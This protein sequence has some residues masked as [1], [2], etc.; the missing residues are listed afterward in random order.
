MFRTWTARIRKHF[1]LAGSGRRGPLS[2]AAKP[3]RL[4][5]ELLEDRWLPTGLTGNQ[6][7]AAYGQ[8]PLSFESNVGQTAAQVDFLSHGPGYGLFLTPTEAVLNLS[9]GTGPVGQA[10]GGN[11]VTMTL[12]GASTNSAPTGLD[13][14]AATSNYFI[15]ND[16]SQ[17]HTNIANYG[18]VQYQNVYSGI[19]LLYYGNQQNLEYDFQVAPGADP[20]VIQLAFS[21]VQSLSL[22][23]QGNLM[24][25]TSGGEVVEQTPVVYQQEGA[26]RQE[27][28]GKYVLEG[29]NQVGF[30]VGAY[31][32][33]QPLTI[34]PV[35]SYATYLGGNGQD[36]GFGIAVDASGDAYVTGETPSN[37][38]PT[39]NPLQP[40]YSGGAIYDAF[41]SR[42]NATGTALVYST[43]LGGGGTDEGKGIALDASGNAYITG[44][45]ESDNF[46]TTTGAFQPT[47][48]GGT[49]AF[50]TKLNAT[51]SALIYSTYLGG[52]T[53]EGYAIALNASGNAYV[54]GWTQ[55][56]FPTT[57]GAFQ[58]KFD[59]SANAFVTELN[60]SG[61]ALVYSTY[62]GGSTYDQ[63][64]GI[65]LDAS[66]DAYVTGY[67]ESSDFPTTSNALQPTFGGGFD[68]A[69]VTELNATGTALVYSTFLGGSGNDEG[70]AIAVDAFGNAYVTGCTESSDFPTVNPIQATF[71]G[72][73]GQGG[74][75][76]YGGDAFVAKVNASGTA[77]IYSTYLG[78]SNDDIGWGIAVDG[79]G[80]A[81]IA[82]ESDSSDFPTT[83]NALQPTL[84]FVIDAV[85]AE[86]NP[87]GTALIYSSF[88]GGS[89]GV[90]IGNAIALD[91]SGNAYVTGYTIASDFSTPYSVQSTS[92]DAGDA[93]VAEIGNIAPQNVTAVNDNFTTT[94][95][96]PT[97]LNVLANDINPQG[98]G[99]Q[100]L[101]ATPIS[102]SGPTLTQ[103]ADG[104]F[105][106]TGADTGTYTFNYTITGAQQEV[107]ADDGAANDDFGASVAISGDTAVVGADRHQVGSNL[108][109]GAAYVF[110]LS[111]TT[112]S[113]QQ[114]LTAANGAA[115]DQF[116][117]SVAINGNN[118]VVGAIQFAVGTSGPG[119]A[120]VYTYSGTSWIQEQELT[121][122]DGAEADRFG[123][124]VALSSD[125]LV[126]GAP[127]HQVG[128]NAREGAAY[129]YVFSGGSWSQ[130]QELTAFDGAAGDQIG[131]EVAINGQ[132][133]VVGDFD[134]TVGDNV[135][136]GAVYVYTFSSPIW[137]L[138]QELTA[139]DGAAHDEFGTSVAIDG[140]TIVVGAFNHK[141][142]GNAGQ[143]AAYV[144]TF[145]G[146]TWNQQQEL[147]ANDGTAND[148]FG[149]SVALDGGT[150]VVGAAGREAAYVYSV[151]GSTWSQ[152][153][154]LT[155]ADGMANAFFGVA[156]ALS[157]DTA[158]V[159]AFGQTVDGNTDQ[160]TAY[161]QT[162]STS[163]ALVTVNVTA[164]SAIAATSGSGQSATVN[165]TF[166]NPLIATVTD[167]DN[168]P[169]AGVTVTFTGPGS[170]AGVT[171]PDG[172]TAIT[173]AEGQASVSVAASTGAGSYIVTASVVGVA[174]AAS[175]TLT[176]NPG[177][178]AAVAFHVQPGNTVAGT[179]I[180]PTVQ[181]Q[182]LDEYGNLEADDSSDQVSLAVASGP[183]SFT[184]AST[185][186]VTVSGGI[187]TFNNLVLDTAGSYILGESA[188]G[189]LS[190][191]S[192]GSFIIDP[193]SADHLAFSVPP[194]STTAGSAIAPA[195][196]VQVFDQYD[197]LA[198]NDNS[199]QVTLSAASGPSAFTSGSTTTVTVSGGIAAFSN[200]ILDTAGSYTLS[201]SGSGGITGPASASFTISPA[202]ADHL[203]FGVP[204]SDTTA[205]A[206]INPAVTVQVFDQY[207]NPA[208]NDNSDQVTL[209]VAS[210]PGTFANGS[211]MTVTV[212]GGVATFSNLMLDT[213]G[214][215][216][217]SES[218]SGGITGPASASFTISP[219]A[220]DHLAFDIQPSDTTAGALINPA[221]TVQVFDQYDNLATNDN[222]DQVTLAVASG[223][224]TFA[225]GSTTTV[226]VNSGVATFSN[227]ILDMAG[228]YTLGESGSGGIT[229]PASTSFTISPAAAD[230]LAF[231][232]QP[233]GTPASAL[234]SPA[235]TVRALDPFGNVVTTDVGDQVTLTVASGPGGFTDG[236]T[237][238]A[239][240]SDGVATFSNL[241]LGT[242][243]SYTLA[244]SDSAGLADA[245]SDGFIVAML[246]VFTNAGAAVFTVGQANS[247]TLTTTDIPTAALSVGSAV[248]PVGVIFVDNG[249]GTATLSGTPA[250]GIGIY[251]FN[252]TARN[253]YTAAVNQVFTLTLIDPPI[254][255]SANNAT[256]PVGKAGSFTVTTTAGLPAATTL[257]RSGTLPSGVTFTANSNGTATLH[258]T[259]AAG[260]GGSY[261]I[262]VT[263]GNAAASQTTQT[264]TLT[265]DQTPTISSAANATFV[266]GQA[267]SFTVTTK[268]FP[269]ATLSESDTLPSGVTFLDNG[270]GTATLSGTPET[271][272]ASLTPYSFTITASNGVAPSVTQTFKLTVD[273][274]PVITSA[275]NATFPVG[276]AGSFT[277]TTTAGL[278]AATTLSESDTLPSGVTFTANSNGTAT[279]KGT[280]AAGTGGSYT[281]TLTASNAAAS[282]TTQTFTLTVDQAPTISSAASTTFVMGQAGNFTVTTKGFPVAALTQSGTL[283]SGVTFLDN[284]NGTAT[285]SGTPGAGT[286]S[287]TP[288]NFT[289]TASNG[290][291][292]S[293]TQTFKL[294]VDQAPVIT[295]AN[296]STFTVGKAGSFTVTTTAGLPAATT[297]S[298]SGTL[299]SGV[300][301]TANS[302]GTATIKGT[303]AAGSGGSYPVTITAGN[304]AASLTTQT[305]TLNV[306]QAPTISSAASAT[307]SVGHAGSFTVTTKGFPAAALTES[308]KLPS[309][310]T[311]LD[312]G[313]GTATLS[314]TPWAGSGGT[315]T[316]TISAGNS[317]ASVAQ[318]FVLMV[319]Q[320]PIITSAASATFSVGQ[321][322]SF[323]ITT[324]GYPVATTI[325]EAGPMPSGVRFVNNGN[326]TA[327]L[328]GK[329]TVKGSFTLTLI[330]SVGG[331]PE[332]IQEFDFTVE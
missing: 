296:S 114:E 12:V 103:N 194:A 124:S 170:G 112:W 129:V 8:I 313:N 214:S 97:N 287:L 138:Q 48:G 235:V 11:V 247:F 2:K 162:F 43:Y 295:S 136:Q 244:A 188:T 261:P 151:A 71:D 7:L 192:S 309:G 115:I 321:L 205:G 245:T 317:V 1:Q 304:A 209:S 298:R 216:T 91:A 331:V 316:F 257:S 263:A 106:F 140:N 260:S 74:L 90:S 45:T 152:Q 135:G 325:T 133:I 56:N 314:G 38:F 40:N 88:L 164:P 327:L 256:F 223:P 13:K 83:V 94:V 320:P 41:V 148:N 279:I 198:T 4:H 122:A 246:P 240:V 120:Y 9:K 156:V 15:G 234:I 51:G 116:G 297:L 172:N 182:L 177:A 273:Q 50:V 64:W 280:P 59:A 187:A 28:A 89:D 218:G 193:G 267:G 25:E 46:P 236:S 255:T 6:I 49:D 139:A 285:L 238:T 293:V 305:F 17:W 29:G 268:G 289:I 181:V 169:V 143:G 253:G 299:P 31:D 213:A 14:L 178:A 176:N 307:F 294:T 110:K 134:H 173:N 284:G 328:S 203:V 332:A 222:S 271:G 101:S 229:G 248:L 290:V 119:A 200:L 282:L 226:T 288:Y 80:D 300:T 118:I 105:T 73:S 65:A 154:E 210:G 132:T 272:T 195:V 301:F 92:G 262:T 63:G 27:V 224:D 219:A 251:T 99:L 60:V 221:V 249:D 24:L 78:G 276:K 189:G 128:S 212:S 137:N 242:A 131:T 23:P 237:T 311:F 58:T 127:G 184:A 310:V 167:A 275:N 32:A 18:Q 264:F 44:F 202:A 180:G 53:A 241:L 85:V 230:H 102:P 220:A 113:L 145:Y 319:D 306:D 100:V 186:T 76:I 291:A 283:P 160:G 149:E 153:R 208:T 312:N 126:I 269:A 199:D 197:N 77:L 20:G 166:A 207:G 84:S 163:S 190:G 16:P 329:P 286:A 36:E 243:G 322:I 215:Y 228:S 3:R 96:T 157:D 318:K 259:P 69:F 277:V 254:I 211:T 81:Y 26:G 125:T 201:E 303:P 179:A 225:D 252:V 22:D 54:T 315:Y 68:D 95:D 130:Q 150:L 70:N 37:N 281:V 142:G 191:P 206:L 171:F 57:S 146:S 185:T 123:N 174:T 108:D 93:F 278:P 21:G 326:G 270:N 61:S 266:M 141:V 232:I 308:G 107:T 292:P 62:L 175:F 324:T 109:Q 250:P 66:G 5:L 75:G 204:P 158:V 183:G 19:S 231:D 98:T 217:Q 39:S 159:G 239:T 155:A 121:A 35:L 86:V 168:N 147:T 227:L 330:V 82:G 30:A 52:G 165:T 274:A 196:T 42:L 34:D 323:S 233:S 67:T 265:V 47:F 117:Y 144:Y 33:S 104:T 55:P 161:I 87:S 10:I 111:G 79:S 302:N 72:G 258:G